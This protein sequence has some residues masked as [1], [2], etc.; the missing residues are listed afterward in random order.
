MQW[1]GVVYRESRHIAVLPFYSISD[2]FDDPFLMNSIVLLKNWFHFKVFIPADI[3][4]QGECEHRGKEYLRVSLWCYCFG[5]I[6]VLEILWQHLAGQ[7]YGV[8]HLE[9]VGSM[10]SPQLEK[11]D[12]W[13]SGQC[14]SLADAELCGTCPSETS[15]KIFIINLK[16]SNTDDAL[17]SG[18]EKSSSKLPHI[19]WSTR[20]TG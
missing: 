2:P 18:L 12:Y 20:T 5:R 16:V 8:L 19:F 17:D 13:L 10:E 4:Y 15:K 11:A 3:Q 7:A 6:Q 14:W 9:N 1:G